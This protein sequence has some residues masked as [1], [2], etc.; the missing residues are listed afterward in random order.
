MNAVVPGEGGTVDTL[1]CFAFALLVAGTAKRPEAAV[2][3]DIEA[4]AAML[5]EGCLKVSR[6]IDT[7]V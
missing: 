6:V 4:T 7:L 3:E 2:P 1:T 5:L